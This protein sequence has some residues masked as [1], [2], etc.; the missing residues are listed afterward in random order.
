MKMM[1]TILYNISKFDDF[2]KQFLKKY[3]LFREIYKRK[4]EKHLLNNNSNLLILDKN[5]DVFEYIKKR[6]RRNLLKMTRRYLYMT[7]YFFISHKRNHSLKKYMN[8][9]IISILIMLDSV[10]IF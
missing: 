1:K 7:R 2:K 3:F 5:I 10:Y 9:A 6:N 4:Q 8:Y